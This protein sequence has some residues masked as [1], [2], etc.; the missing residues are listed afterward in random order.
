MDQL[1]ADGWL[2]P[3]EALRRMTQPAPLS[4]VKATRADT[5]RFG[6]R[7][8]SMRLLVGANILSEL[9][10]TPEIF[11]IPNMPAALRGYVNRQGALLPIWDLRALV[12]T[13]GET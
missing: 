4:D 12:E 9:L 2:S 13:T 11:P 5:V 6:Y 1:T 7:V 8:G 3:S 10:E